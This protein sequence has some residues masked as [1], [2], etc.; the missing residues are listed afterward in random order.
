MI[1]QVYDDDLLNGVGIR[2]VVFLQG[3]P[4]HCKGCFNPETWEF[5][6]ETEESRKKDLYYIEHL[7]NKLS[8]SYISG[9]TISGGD[10]FANINELEEL[11]ELAK[12]CNKNIWVY[13]GFTYEYLFKKY[14]DILKSIDVLCDGPFIEYLKSPDKPWVGSSNQRVIDVQKSLKLGSI[15]EL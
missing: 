5:K 2:E 15:C 10:P 4:H 11:I 12:S 13:T 9:L 14:P 3:C 8:K 7:K 1:V 6:K